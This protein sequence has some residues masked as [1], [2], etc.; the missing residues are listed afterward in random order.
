LAGDVT[1]FEPANAN[2]DKNLVWPLGA[3]SISELE[4]ESC[5]TNNLL[6]K[7]KQE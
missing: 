2:R 6:T 3:A 4:E 5:S 1:T 7:D